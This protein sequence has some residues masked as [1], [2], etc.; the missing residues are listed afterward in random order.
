MLVRD[1]GTFKK[2]VGS[3]KFHGIGMEQVACFSERK[4][5]GLGALISPARKSQL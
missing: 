1:A 2:L 5:A 4:M 3:L